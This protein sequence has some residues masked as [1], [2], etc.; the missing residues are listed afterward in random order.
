[1]ENNKLA[2]QALDKVVPYTWTKLD[3]EEI[4]KLLA[5]HQELVVKETMDACIGKWY[6]LNMKEVDTEDKRA[7]AIH[8]GQKNGLLQA[9]SSIK[10]RFGIEE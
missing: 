6:E 5:Y 1:M 10:K 4:H 8:V 7:V 9:I 3:Y 2:G